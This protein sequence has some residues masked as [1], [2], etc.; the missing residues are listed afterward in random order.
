[1]KYRYTASNSSGKIVDGNT[2]A[3]TAAEVLG[4]LA[5][6]GLKPIS[7]K[8]MGNVE[9]LGFKKMF[10]A[11]ITT[12]DKVFLTKYLALM[13]KV[14]TD[15]YKA[16][17]ILIADFDKQAMKLLLIEIKDSLAKGQPLYSTFA[18]YPRYFSSVFVN[19]IKAGEASGNLDK[20]LEDM[21]A[22]LEKQEN[23]RKKIKSVLVYPAVLL[24]L[25][26]LI[27]LGL[28][29][30]AL[31]KIAEIFTSS[32]LKPPLFSRVVFAIGLF[33]G[34][35]LYIILPGI[36]G[37]SLGAFFFFRRTAIGRRYF[38]RILN[39]TVAIN[40]VIFRIAIQRFAST[41]ASLLKA[42]MPIIDALEITASAVGF[43]ELEAAI[44]RVKVSV[45]KGLTIGESFQ[46]ETF[47]PKVVVNLISVSEKA[48]HI[49]DILVT[50][51]DF[52]E[53]EIESS[54]KTLLSLVEPILLVFIGGIVGMI[55]L[56][57]IV[58]IYQLVG[59]V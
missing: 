17:D 49:D 45:T 6:Q 2:E 31:P 18:R 37:L 51:G 13:L 33:L 55:A 56:A 27:M 59:T 44:L 5:G 42:G 53:F 12:Q 24:S 3:K 21:S 22:S 40:Q 36:I 34:D 28:V 48:G 54:I 15:L 25:T 10:G 57:I 14:G 9:V 32:S 29:S 46:K 50:L 8:S 26:L 58:P 35:N 1:M 47:F 4:F 52:Y 23:L 16:I 39:K 7:I 20:V 41:L 11:A 19:M 43:P 38:D 30:F